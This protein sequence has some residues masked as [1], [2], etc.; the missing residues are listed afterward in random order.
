MLNSEKKLAFR[1]R[2]KKYSN[3]PVVRKFFS[4][5]NKKP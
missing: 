1:A 4:K 2:K 5:R 3:S